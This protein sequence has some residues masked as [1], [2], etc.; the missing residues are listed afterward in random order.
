MQTGESAEGREI[1]TAPTT[2]R[3]A[4]CRNHTSQLVIKKFSKPQIAGLV[5]GV[6]FLVRLETNLIRAA[7][8]EKPVAPLVLAPGACRGRHHC[9]DLG[10]E[11]R[12][13]TNSSTQEREA[14]IRLYFSAKMLLQIGMLARLGPRE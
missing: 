6:L 3:H 7:A 13:C 5:I 14:T 12:F 4:Q 1:S 11:K 9:W 10:K 8:E 2:S